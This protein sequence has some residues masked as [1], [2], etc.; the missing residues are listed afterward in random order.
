MVR[1]VLLVLALGGGPPLL[2]DLASALWTADQ[3]NAGNSYDPDGATADSDAGNH[4]DP[5]G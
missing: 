3:T 1:I 5:N 2:L 4:T